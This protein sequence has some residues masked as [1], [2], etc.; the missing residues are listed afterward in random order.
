MQ[1]IPLTHS[2]LWSFY[3]AQGEL[4]QI[5]GYGTWRKGEDFQL[6]GFL[7]GKNAEYFGKSIV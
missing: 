5:K 3:K 1:E 4:F 7:K 2:S 6:K